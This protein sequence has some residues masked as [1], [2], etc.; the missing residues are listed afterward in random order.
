L[1]KNLEM[2]VDLKHKNTGYNL[3]DRK[4]KN[5]EEGNTSV[6]VLENGS[7]KKSSKKRL[8]DSRGFTKIQVRH[9]DQNASDSV[10]EQNASWFDGQVFTA[11]SILG[12]RRRKGK[13]EYLVKWEGWSDKYNSWEREK[14]ILDLSLIEDFEREKSLLSTPPKP[15]DKS[16]LRKTKLKAENSYD[17]G[18]YIIQET[19]SGES[20]Y[21]TQ[22]SDTI[23]DSI[24]ELI[25]KPSAQSQNAVPNQSLK[26]FL[27][28]IQS[29]DLRYA[30]GIGVFFFFGIGNILWN[31]LYYL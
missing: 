2:E 21:E 3:R 22:D 27:N 5:E 11:E 4:A 14:H 24:E 13:I 20:D 28:S 23:G 19:L 9:Q 30:I 29:L 31:C 15:K 18:P 1:A 16:M 12:K 10:E 7:G 17:A 25:E 26:K 6:G 8:S